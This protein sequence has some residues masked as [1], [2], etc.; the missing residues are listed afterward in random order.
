MKVTFNQHI[1]IFENAVPKEWCE[2][3]IKVFEDNSN[4]S[5]SRIDPTTSKDDKFMALHWY[6]LS[7]CQ[8]FDK[9]FFKNIY[10][11]YSNKYKLD[12]NVIEAPIY[13]N[14]HKIQKT[15]LSE[16]YHLWHIESS[17]MM[18]E[19]LHR[20]MVYTVYLNDVEEGGETEF[21][22]QNLRVKPKQGTICL[23][24]AGYTHIHRGNPPLSNTKYIMTGWINFQQIFDNTPTNE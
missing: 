6:D 5:K 10:P 24:P 23:F 21:L 12:G 13:L 3:V 16:G 7:L 15:D 19:T 22:I 18:L 2:K 17:P 11:L 20:F 8:V 14:D 1:G 4:S 9:N